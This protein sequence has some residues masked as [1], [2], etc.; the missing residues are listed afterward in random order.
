MKQNKILPINITEQKLY[1]KTELITPHQ[2]HN[3]TINSFSIALKLYSALINLFLNYISANHL[4]LQ[5]NYFY[6]DKSPLDI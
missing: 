2:K 1:I 4:I 5:I 6:C 3:R